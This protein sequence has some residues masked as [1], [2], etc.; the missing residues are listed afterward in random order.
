ML[1]P[2]ARLRQKAEAGAEVVLTQPPLLWERT[3]RW[4]EEAHSS[5]LSS[6]V[7]VGGGWGRRS[8]GGPGCAC[9]TARRPEAGGGD[10]GLVQLSTALACWHAGC[11]SCQAASLSAFKP[12]ALCISAARALCSRRWQ[13]H[14]SA[15]TVP[16]LLSQPATFE[17][18]SFRAAPPLTAPHPTPH[19][20][21]YR[22]T[23][24]TGCAGP[25]HRA[26]C[27]QPG[28]LAAPVRR[29]APARGAGPAAGLPPAGTGRGGRRPAAQ[30][31]SAC[32][33]G[34]A[35]ECRPDQKGGQAGLQGQ[36]R[37]AVSSGSAH[38]CSPAWPYPCTA[39]ALPGPAGCTW[40]AAPPSLHRTPQ[41]GQLRPSTPARL[42]PSTPTPPFLPSSPACSR[43]PWSCPASPACTSCPS[44]SLRG[45]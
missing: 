27:R 23:P 10:Q 22:P 6:N 45:S 37:S 33:G 7:K 43:S 19:P 25:A 29:A 13:Q 11:P 20:S 4:A 31:G 34:A 42:L 39:A 41:E 26:L 38:P 12:A 21:T 40:F 28:L 5:L 2:V 30:Q 17:P 9:L 36:G 35:V 14:G 24:H 3:A 44:P 1:A 18:C 16:A 32:G 8:R 15:F